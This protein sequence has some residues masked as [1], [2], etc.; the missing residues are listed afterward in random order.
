M[1]PERTLRCTVSRRTRG[2][3]LGVRHFSV[4]PAGTRRLVLRLVRSLQLSR[5]LGYSFARRVS[6]AHGQPLTRGAPRAPGESITCG[7]LR[8]PDQRFG[9]CLTHPQSASS[10]WSFAR[11][12]SHT[13]FHMQCLERPRSPSRASLDGVWGCHAQ[14]L[15]NCQAGSHARHLAC[16][17]VTYRTWR[18]TRPHPGGVSDAPGLCLA[19]SFSRTLDDV[20]RTASR[21][22][23]GSVPCAPSRAPSH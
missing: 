19:C 18:L 5:T 7:V 13:E 12:I 22:P 11:Y 6:R 14:R 9:R 8:A 10:A 21:A 3:H 2:L 20:S 4:L 16:T 17:R 23:S 15:T 1:R